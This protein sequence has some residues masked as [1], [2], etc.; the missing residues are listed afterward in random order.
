MVER[1]RGESS[2]PHLELD[3][4]GGEQKGGARSSRQPSTSSRSVTNDLLNRLEAIIGDKEDL[5]GET[6]A[7]CMLAL[8]GQVLHLE[9]EVERLNTSLGDTNA[10]LENANPEI[11]AL[12]GAVTWPPQVIS[13]AVAAT[14]QPVA[15][16]W[17][18][19]PSKF[20]GDRRAKV[21]NFFVGYGALFSCSPHS[22]KGAGS[23]LCRLPCWRCEVTV[24]D[25]GC[26]SRWCWL[27]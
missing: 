22:T 6:L 13:P 12:K 21:V 25:S 16:R 19:E 17:I 5:E 1:E 10:A 11:A 14:P 2:K 27:Q 24:E 15:V 26:S 18:P 3:E 20:N 23:Y 8:R 4:V 9:S 7:Q